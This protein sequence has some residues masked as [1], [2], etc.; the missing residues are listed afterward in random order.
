MRDIKPT[1]NKIKL[2]DA[3]ADEIRSRLVSQ[4]RVTHV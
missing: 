4:K 1:I 2:D 3:K